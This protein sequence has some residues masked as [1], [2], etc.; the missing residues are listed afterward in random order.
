MSVVG[1][2]HAIWHLTLGF[3][4]GKSV[5]KTNIT[6]LRL[7]VK[8]QQTCDV[9]DRG[10]SDTPSHL[11]N[12]SIKEVISKCKHQYVR[13]ACGKLKNHSQFVWRDT[14]N[15]VPT[16]EVVTETL[17]RVQLFRVNFAVPTRI[18]TSR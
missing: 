6:I 16:E 7:N 12:I 2:D 4:S 5:N 13:P 8:K 9:S 14:G 11:A 18:S 15:A 3:P 1:Y 17:S 10:Q